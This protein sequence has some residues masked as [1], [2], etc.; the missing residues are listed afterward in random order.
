MIAIPKTGREN[1]LYDTLSKH[2]D[3]WLLKMRQTIQAEREKAYKE[4]WDSGMEEAQS[5]C[6]EHSKQAIEAERSRIVGIVESL[7]RTE[8]PPQDMIGV[9]YKA[10]YASDAAH[11][12]AL[13]SLITRIKE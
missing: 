5:R 6:L 12:G 2:A 11:N 10:L 9:D 4:G 7:K 8:W 3:W 13:D 1:L